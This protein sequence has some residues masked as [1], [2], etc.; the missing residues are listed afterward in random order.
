MKAI[1][2]KPTPNIT[3]SGEKLNVFLQ[4]LEQDKGCHF[5]QYSMGSL[6]QNNEVRKKKTSYYM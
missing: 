1:Y 4:D 3:C 2:D 5:I 6:V